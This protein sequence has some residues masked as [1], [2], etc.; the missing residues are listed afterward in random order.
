[1]FKI[2]AVTVQTAIPVDRSVDRSSKIRVVAGS[3]STARL[4]EKY[5]EQMSYSQ[6]GSGRPPGW[7]WNMH[8]D[9]HCC[10]NLGRLGRSTGFTWHR[11]GRPDGRPAQ[12]K[13]QNKNRILKI[14]WF[15]IKYFWIGISIKYNNEFVNRRLY[16]KIFCTYY[17]KYFWK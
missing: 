13:G 17:R 1:M 11:V 4:T 9:T 6:A 5:R 15:L 7:Q 10:Q 16:I 2:I 12:V 3:R 14:I 8:T